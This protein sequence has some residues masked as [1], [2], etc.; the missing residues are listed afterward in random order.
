MAIVR[1]TLKTDTKPTAKQLA[2]VRAAA[3]APRVYDPDCPPLTKEEL[4]QFKRVNQMR[5]EKREAERM[6]VVSLRLRPET[7]EK[8]RSIGKGYTSVLSQIIEE[9]LNDPSLVKKF[10]NG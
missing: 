9:V 5:K 1:A 6:Q 10:I 2:E 8:A 3:L 7:M 4:R